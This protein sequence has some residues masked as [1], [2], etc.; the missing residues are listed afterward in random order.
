MKKAKRMAAARVLHVGCNIIESGLVLSWRV[1]WG[2]DGVNSYY[3][4]V[5]TDK[6][7]RLIKQ[8]YNVIRGAVDDVRKIANIIERH[9]R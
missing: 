9:A 1:T 2:A 4:A 7:Y 8:R 5:L 3:E 6:E